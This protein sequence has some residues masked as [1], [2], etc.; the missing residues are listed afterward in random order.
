VRTPLACMVI[1]A[2]RRPGRVGRGRPRELRDGGEIIRRHSR[3]KAKQH[4]RHRP[5]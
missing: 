3:L 1:P 4:V 2:Q 5:S